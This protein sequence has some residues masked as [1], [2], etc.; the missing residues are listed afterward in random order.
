MNV[1]TILTWIAG[2][3]P[4]ASKMTSQVHDGLALNVAPPRLR[5]SQN[6]AQGLANAVW[7]ALTWDSQIEDTDGMHA[8]PSSNITAVTPGL[9]EFCAT[10]SFTV[11]ATGIRFL[12]FAL[13]GNALPGR[14]KGPADA[15]STADVAL[16]QLVRMAVGDTLTVLAYQNAG[17]ALNTSIG[18]TDGSQS[19]LQAVWVAG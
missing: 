14:A 17:G 12:R 10:V 9:Y 7:A 19:S 4:G 3:I 18:T 5:L 16:S 11:N 13:N 8:A 15:S 1:P 6:V 2:E